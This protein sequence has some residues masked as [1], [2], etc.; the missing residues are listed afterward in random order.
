MKGEFK[1]KLIGNNLIEKVKNSCHLSKAQLAL[2]C[3]YLDGI[4][5]DGTL[6]PDFG[7]F[8]E[9]LLEASGSELDRNDLHKGM[10]VLTAYQDEAMNCALDIILY[11]V[12]ICIRNGVKRSNFCR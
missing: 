4:D 11:Y 12:A 10:K 2:D 8:F 9:A 3:G 1:S 7:G 5:A 6:V